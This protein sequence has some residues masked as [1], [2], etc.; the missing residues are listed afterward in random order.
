MAMFNSYVKLPGGST[1]VAISNM[2]KQSL[3]GIF[4]KSALK[5]CERQS[6]GTSIGMLFS[7]GLG[8]ELRVSTLWSSMK[9][10]HKHP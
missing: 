5:G 4:S 6:K 9:N 8:A 7:A 2:K 3:H 1:T 10:I